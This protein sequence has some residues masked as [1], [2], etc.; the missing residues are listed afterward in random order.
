MEWPTAEEMAPGRWWVSA[1]VGRCP[2]TVDTPCHSYTAQRT[3]SIWSRQGQTCNRSTETPLKP[4]DDRKKTG[5]SRMQKCNKRPRSK[6]ATT[7]EEGKSNRQLHERTKQ[8]TGAMSGRREHITWGPRTNTRVGSSEANSRVIY[9][10]TETE[11]LDTVEGSAPSETK[12]ETT[13][14]EKRNWGYVSSLRRKQC[15]MY[16]RC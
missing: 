14:S 3:L 13:A 1:E 2:R 6:A 11:W 9:W 12:K 5:G 4:L 15:G 10:G 16:M 8:E 7:S